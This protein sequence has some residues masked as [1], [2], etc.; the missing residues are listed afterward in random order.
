MA[1]VETIETYGGIGAIG[2]VPI[3]VTQE[4]LKMETEGTCTDPTA[5]TDSELAMAKAT[6]RDEF[7]AGLMLSGANYNRY[8]LLRY[9][10]ANQYGFGNYLYPKTVDQCLTM[11]NR[12][13]DAAPRGPRNQ[14]QQQ[15]QQRDAAP[16]QEEEA[17]V[18][19]QGADSRG[20]SK[21]SHESSGKKSS[22][23]STGSSSS[24]SVKH[25]P[26]ITKVFCKNCGK[27][28]H[29]S[30]VCPELK[31]PP[32]Q[33]HAMAMGQDDASDSSDD[34]SVIIPTQFGYFCSRLLCSRGTS[35]H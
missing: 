23:G 18:F 5:P 24:S 2:I 11:L 25:P 15:Q 17:L 28:G 32:A 20:Q 21:S 8:N 30:T 12:R 31:P 4:L 13:K 29:M 19:T 9:E 6:V 14:Q 10:L 26:K 22:K 1:H 7:L 27:L 3:F 35:S 33:I 16:K 34:E